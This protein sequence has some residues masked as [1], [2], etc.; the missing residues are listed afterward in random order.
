MLSR[1]ERIRLVNLDALTYAGSLANLTGLESYETRYR[2][3]QGDIADADLVS[4][5]ISKNEVDT[6]VHLAA[7]SHVDRSIDDPE[8]FLKT[9]IMGTFVLLHA[10]RQQWKGR[11]DVRFH[12]VSTDEVYGSLGPGEYFHEMSRYDP[13]SPY[14]ASKAGSDH[15][16]RAW[17]RTYGL[18]VTLSNCSNNYGPFQF[19][20]KLIPLMIMSALR[21]KPLPV[22][23]DGGNVRDWVHVHDHC[24][25]LDRVIRCGTS[26]QTYLIGGDARTTNLEL[27]HLLCDLLM[28]LKPRS[29]GHYRDL[30]EMVP[31]RPGHDRRYA[32][33]ISHIRDEL[34]WRPRRDLQTGLAETLRWYLEHQDWL[35][36]IYREKY[37]GQRL[38][39]QR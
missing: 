2:F 10:A 13:S 25:A 7:E 9:N 8:R 30:V 1:D 33:D 36:A 4:C 5:L 34:D 28:D 32:T 12:H 27:V 21:D 31:D 35:E 29:H 37:P 17:S 3:V 11:Q 22:Y 14:S 20:E 24:R 16:V 23:G 38:G 26:G 6:V 19:P 15:L 39:L 18:N